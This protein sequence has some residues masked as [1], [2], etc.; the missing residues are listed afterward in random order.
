MFLHYYSHFQWKI[1]AS[2]SIYH[3]R[4]GAAGRG[5]RGK[6]LKIW[7]PMHVTT[8]DESPIACLNT[9]SAKCFLP[10]TASGGGREGHLHVEKLLCISLTNEAPRNDVGI[11]AAGSFIAAKGKSNLKQTSF[12]YLH[13]KGMQ[14][15]IMFSVIPVGWHCSFGPGKGKPQYPGKTNSNSCS[16]GS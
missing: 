15:E 6:R 4:K 2:V 11:A 14:Q 16:V 9:P 13:L 12:M 7:K 1:P 8:W 3:L 5:G 10:S